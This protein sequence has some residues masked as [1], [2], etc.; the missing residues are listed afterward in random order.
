MNLGNLSMVLA[1]MYRDGLTIEQGIEQQIAGP[2]AEAAPEPIIELAPLPLPDAIGSANRGGPIEFRP[3]EE[4][5][6]EAEQAEEMPVPQVS[7]S[8]VMLPVLADRSGSEAEDLPEA[9]LPEAHDV[10]EET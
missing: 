1:E 5:P 7:D 4:V 3:A 2:A 9:A 10:Q 8:P 6:S